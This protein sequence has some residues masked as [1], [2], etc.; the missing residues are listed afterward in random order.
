[1]SDPKGISILIPVFNNDIRPLV[2]S[3]LKQAQILSIPFEIRCYDDFSPTEIKNINREISSLSHI[4]YLELKKNI[5]RSRIRNKLATDALYNHLLFLDCDSEIHKETFLHDYTNYLSEDVIIGGRIYTPKP[6]SRD[7]ILHWKAG[8]EKEERSL[9][10]RISKPYH[11]FMTNNFMIR[12]SVYF[13]IKLD[14][15]LEGYGHEDTKFGY[16]LQ[17][18]NIRITHIDNPVIHGQLDSNTE[19]LSKTKQGVK[20][21]SKLLDQGYGVDSKLFKSYSLVKKLRLTGIFKWNYHFNQKMIE[22]NLNSS[23]PSLLYFDLYKLYHLLEE[24]G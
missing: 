17:K 24:R 4:I 7:S 14:E 16:E 13:E 6:V 23:D 21:F 22:G 11:S 20:N 12:K 5:G 3:L 15:T 9:E 8:K 19:F 18:R 2:F 1:M 10:E